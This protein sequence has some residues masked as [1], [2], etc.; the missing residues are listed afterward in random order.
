MNG[1]QITESLRSR[2]ARRRDQIIR[3]P[4]NIETMGQEL[5][6]SPCRSAFL[7]VGKQK[8]ILVPGN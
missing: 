1:F 7:G 8:E 4:K 2:T 3:A 6:A 5:E